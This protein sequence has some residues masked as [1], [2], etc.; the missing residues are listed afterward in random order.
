[1][2]TIAEEIK[3]CEK[4]SDESYLE[5]GRLLLE[6][7][8]RK[9]YGKYGKWLDWLKEVDIPAYKAQRMIR[10]AEWID[11]KETPVSHLGFTKLYVLSR[12]SHDDFKSFRERNQI[13]RMSKRELQKAVCNYLREKASERTST[14]TTITQQQTNVSTEDDLRQRFE[15]IQDEVSKLA[16]LIK[17]NP[18]QYEHLAEELREFVVQQLSADDV[19]ED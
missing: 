12:L 7:R 6:A 1:M 13:E 3:K 9:D 15:K 2:E 8:R 11:G 4:A 14:A 5:I 19:E 10:V 17:E 18:G 16:G